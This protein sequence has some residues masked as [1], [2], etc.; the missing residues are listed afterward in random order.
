MSKN[1]QMKP[2]KIIKPILIKLDKI[3]NEKN[4]EKNHK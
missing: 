1:E 2:I 3:K 4:L